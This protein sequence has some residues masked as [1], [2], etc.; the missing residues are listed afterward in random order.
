VYDRNGDFYD[1]SAGIEARLRRFNSGMACGQ[2][3]VGN[4]HRCQPD[5]ELNA[6]TTWRNVTASNPGSTATRQ[7]PASTHKVAGDRPDRTRIWTNPV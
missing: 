4:T 6:S 5:H 3:V 1:I 7:F 2:N